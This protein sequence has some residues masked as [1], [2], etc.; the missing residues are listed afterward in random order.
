MSKIAFI[1]SGQGAQYCGMGKELY[2]CSDMVKNVFQIAET[3]R[4][5]TSNQCFSGTKEELSQTI[6]TQP[7]LFCV[8][9][10]AAEALRE[11]GIEP[12]M[13]AGFSLGEIPALTFGGAFGA[14]DRQQN[15][16]EGF[17]LVC[18]R[19]EF[20]E[21][22]TRVSGGAMTAILGLMSEKVEELCASVQDTYPVN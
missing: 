15:I 10:G 4:E 20:M 14:T 16:K 18:K 21:N 11:A 17:K 13:A 7:T 22:C 9:L 12:D 8:G 6:N 3:I 19:A 1:F 2:E 5:G